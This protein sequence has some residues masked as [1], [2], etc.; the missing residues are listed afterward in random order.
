MKRCARPRSRRLRLGT[1]AHA[2][3][4][5]GDIWAAALPYD[6]EELGKD[7]SL[8]HKRTR[9]RMN[10]MRRADSWKEASSMKIFSTRHSLTGRTFL[11]ARI[12]SSSLTGC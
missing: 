9:Q 12:K 10:E 5:Q 11:Y 1:Q 6:W 7:L 4:R 3:I 8:F 2:V